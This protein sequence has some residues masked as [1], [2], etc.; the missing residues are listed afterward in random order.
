M[1]PQT[2][3]R[4]SD[5]ERERIAGRIQHASTEGRLTLAETDQRLGDVYA[6]TY[7]DE[8]AGFVADLPPEPVPH[9]RFPPPL[10]AHAAVVVLLSTLLVVAWAA[11]GAPFFWPVAPMFWLALSLVVHAGLRARRAAVPY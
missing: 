8:L 6:A 9:R 1:N 3:T 4:A 10:R 5:T 2:R 11:S 7:V